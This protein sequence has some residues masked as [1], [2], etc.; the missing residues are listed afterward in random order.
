MWDK[1]IGRLNMDG[2]NGD[3]MVVEW[4]QIS[5]PTWGMG[6]NYFSPSSSLQ[7]ISEPLC[8]AYCSII[9]RS[10]CHVVSMNLIDY[11]IMHPF[12]YKL[13]ITVNFIMVPGPYSI[14]TIGHHLSWPSINLNWC[15]FPSTLDSLHWLLCS[16]DLI[17]LTPDVWYIVFDFS[18]RT[19]FPELWYHSSNTKPPICQF[20]LDLRYLLDSITAILSICVKIILSGSP[21]FIALVESNLSP[22]IISWSLIFDCQIIII[23]GC[24]H[25]S[26]P[27]CQ[28]HII[29]YFQVHRTNY[30]PMN[31]LQ[32]KTISRATFAVHTKHGYPFKVFVNHLISLWWTNVIS[33]PTT[34]LLPYSTWHL[35]SNILYRAFASYVELIMMSSWSDILKPPVLDTSHRII[36]SS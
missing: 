5:N 21:C 6:D 27:T 34:P 10:P 15:I 14:S 20:G 22:P 30:D 19:P 35:I 13:F 11:A 25:H 12:W 36:W 8:S 29:G 7:R 16:I 28:T 17:F 32:Y 24:W 33:F 1:W 3:K 18:Y 4:C 9:A 31:F 2:E 26:S 23:S